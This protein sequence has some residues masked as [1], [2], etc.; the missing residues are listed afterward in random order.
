MPRMGGRSEIV[1]D[2]YNMRYVTVTYNRRSIFTGWMKPGNKVQIIPEPPY[3]LVVK[4]Y[5]S[6]PGT[7]TQ[8]LQEHTVKGRL[9]GRDAEASFVI[10]IGNYSRSAVG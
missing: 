1:N 7:M 10:H 5:A 4:A 3:T 8:P 2:S 6:L 9:I